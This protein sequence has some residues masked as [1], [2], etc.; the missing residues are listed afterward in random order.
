MAGVGGGGRGD[1]CGLVEWSLR[2]IFMI[3]FNVSLLWSFSVKEKYMYGST[4]G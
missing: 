4:D 3:Y 2:V 1:G